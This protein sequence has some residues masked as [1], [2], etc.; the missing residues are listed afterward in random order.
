MNLDGIKYIFQIPLAW[1]KR[2]GEFVFHSYGGNLIQIRR[3]RNGA[4]EI[5]VDP[6]EFRDRVNEVVEGDF[7]TIGTDQTI[8]STKT[9]S[10]GK[11]IILTDGANNSF[12][13]RSVGSGA[14]F[15]VYVGA[16][17]NT[18]ATASPTAV[19]IGGGTV[20][21]VT[22]GDSNVTTVALGKDPTDTTSTTSKAVATLGW[23]NLHFWRP[24]TTN[25]GVVYNTNGTITYKSI[26]T[27]NNDIAAGHHTHPAS[28]ITGLPSS[29]T[30]YDSTPA[31]LTTNGSAGSSNL[32]SR[33]DHSH[34]LPDITDLKYT[35]GSHT[36]TCLL[37]VQNDGTVVH[38]GN[39]MYNNCYALSNGYQAGSITIQNRNE[40]AGQN[41]TIIGSGFLELYGGQYAYIDFHFNNSSADF[42]SRI[43][44]WATGHL[45]INNHPTDTDLD[46]SS[47]SPVTSPAL[48]IATCGF[49]NSKM[50]AASPSTATN[51]APTG[52]AADN[53]TWTAGNSVGVTKKVLYRTKYVQGNL[54][55]ILY[56]Y[57][58][59]E[60]YDQFGRLYS[61]SAETREVIDQTILITLS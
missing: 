56:G 16:F 60:T 35:D 34:P 49:V 47:T 26:G 45:W 46:M 3:D 7:V 61:I 43:I 10:A 20:A 58:R 28:D 38:S 14:G 51:I 57:Y 12:V 4:A 52:D 42:T 53:T 15:V 24:S 30:P 48:Q 29:P 37:I 50:T 9:F 1:F 33:G 40:G 54:T 5:G 18:I 44:E 23:V 22:L 27:G 13:V 39:E 55:P 32:Y 25:T 19:R 31:D 41:R 2:V 8:T 36:G 11:G 6:D 17:D 21:T 59:T